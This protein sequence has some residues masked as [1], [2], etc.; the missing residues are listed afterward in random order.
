MDI[1]ILREYCLAKPYTTEGTPFGPDPLVMKV[2]GKM[3]C[4]F[5]IL[6][7]GRELKM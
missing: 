2:H 5:S 1:E 6:N 7:F 4:L 3:F